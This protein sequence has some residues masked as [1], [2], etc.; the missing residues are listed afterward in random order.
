M[1]QKVKKVIRNVN[2][3]NEWA[4]NESSRQEIYEKPRL[5]RSI[6][7]VCSDDSVIYIGSYQ[8]NSR[9]E[10]TPFLDLTQ[11]SSDNLHKAISLQHTKPLQTIYFPTRNFDRNIKLKKSMATTSLITLPVIEKQMVPRKLNSTTVLN[12]AYKE[13]LAVLEL[14]EEYL[15][16]PDVSTDFTFFEKARLTSSDYKMIDWILDVEKDIDFSLSPS[17]SGY[18]SSLDTDTSTEKICNIYPANSKDK[19]DYL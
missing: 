7:K 8:D 5:L 11:S 17:T 14:P 18:N 4:E 12:S 2:L 19:V 6:K 10:S 15:D 1:W 9:G 13:K 16:A 3:L